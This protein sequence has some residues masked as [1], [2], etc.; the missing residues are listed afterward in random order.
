MSCVLVTHADLPLGLRIVKRLRAEPAVTGIV[1]LGEGPLPEALAAAAGAT[2]VRLVYQRVDHARPRAMRELFRG[3]LLRERG[4][5]AVV[6]VPRHGDAARGPRVPARVPARTAEARILLRQVLEA[7][8]VRV[9]VALGSA[10]A[11]ALAPGNANHLGEE[12]A[13]DLAPRRPAALRAWI[14]S[15]M[16]FHAEARRRRPRVVLLRLPTVVASG[17]AVYLHPA[18]EGPPGLRP[19]PAGFDPL[20]PVIAD[21][22]VAR[23]VAAALACE[24]GG[25]FNV[26]GREQIPLSVLGRW[27]GRPCLPVPGPLLG[28]A[29]R[30]LLP[31]LVDGPYLR[32]GMSLDTRRARHLLGFEPHY[33]VG[34]TRAGDGAMRLEAMPGP[35]A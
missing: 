27:T 24:N 9:L 29:A 4:V 22:D 26:A 32:F 35:G 20:C 23:A 7:R 11:Y 14:D 8:E 33:R 15:D 16:L 30:A 2:D 34:V 12:S 17:G 1:A 6:Y 21:K 5:D 19:R 3:P 18:F 13:L 10:F 28:V 31:S 25:I